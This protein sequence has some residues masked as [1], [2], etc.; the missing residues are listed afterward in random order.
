MRAA[1]T[2]RPARRAALTLEAYLRRATRGLPAAERLDAAAELRTHLLGRVAEHQAQGFSREEA[3]FLA[4]R[5][6][7][8]P[9]PVNRGLLGHAFTHR[10]GWLTLGALLLSGLGWVTYRE[11]LP[12]R[13]GARFEAVN[14]QDVAAL[15]AASDAPRGI[16]QAVTLTLPK[17]TQ[18]VIFAH[19]S[20]SA[21]GRQDN[22][23]V[24]TYP[25]AKVTAQNIRGRIPG[26]Y[27][28]QLRLL[29]TTQRLT[30]GGQ[31]QARL[32]AAERPWPS[33][34]WNTGA[35]LSGGA[36]SAST[37]A[38]DDPRVRLRERGNLFRTVVRPDGENAVLTGHQPLH[39]NEWTVLARLIV[40]PQADPDASGL[41]VGGYSNQARGSYVA[42]MPL[43]RTAGA[44][45]GSSERPGLIRLSTER[46]PL[47]PLPPAVP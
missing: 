5:A 10:A 14:Q 9:Q 38:C 25:A 20:G 3:E 46:E 21:G 42:V 4:V 16:Y 31:P 6:M 32:Y 45:D 29:L 17:G 22:L 19:L 12:P 41:P 30:C 47:P 36:V 40:D 39:L 27:R 13:E 33:P 23:M 35:H 24:N 1:R 43:N 2:P 11:W 18:S 15:F 28:D 37:E 8:D 7:G 44:W 34:F 26:S